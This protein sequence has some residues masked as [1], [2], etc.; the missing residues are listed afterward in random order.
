[1]IMRL[2]PAGSVCE[3]FGTTVSCDLSAVLTFLHLLGKELNSL[4]KPFV[5]SRSHEN[6]D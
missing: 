1:M 3:V 2:E 6:T 5:A 4:G